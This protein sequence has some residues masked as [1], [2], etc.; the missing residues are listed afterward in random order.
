M[1]LI[2]F[3]CREASSNV[4]VQPGS[5]PPVH[6]G[7]SIGPSRERRLRMAER[8]REKLMGTEI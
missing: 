8:H 7:S 1:G 5:D 4:L 6:P 3:Y 2:V